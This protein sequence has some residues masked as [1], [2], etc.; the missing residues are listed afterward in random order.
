MDFNQSFKYFVDMTNAKFV[1]M[2]EEMSL[3]RS[4]FSRWY[5]SKVLPNKDLWS[6]I[7]KKMVKYFSERMTP[8]NIEEFLTLRNSIRSEYDSSGLEIV[9]DSVLNSG[10]KTSINRLELEEEKYITDNMAFA[11][12]TVGEFMDVLISNINMTIG[13]ESKSRVDIYYSDDLIDALDH[14]F[15]DGLNIPFTSDQFYQFNYLANSNDDLKDREIIFDKITKFFRLSEKLPFMDFKIYED[16]DLEPINKFVVADKLGGYSNKILDDDYYMGFA[17]KNKETIKLIEEQLRE[18]FSNLNLVIKS[19]IDFQ[20][21]YKRMEKSK[22]KNKIKMFLP[23]LS[24]FMFSYDLREILFDKGVIDKENYRV[25][26]TVKSFFEHP[27]IMS[28]DIS[29]PESSIIK[30]VNNGIITTLKGQIQLDRDEIKLIKKEY[31]DFYEERLARSKINIISTDIQNIE[32]LPKALIYSDKT[33]SC[34]IRP[35]Y[36][37]KTMRGEFYNSIE[38]PYLSNM[39]YEYLL[40]LEKLNEGE[41][42][43]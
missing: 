20:E 9:I 36:Q 39:F 12:E 30:F 10:Y 3:D 38:T 32:R 11:I 40:A 15:I 5:N 17:L 13:D 43:L 25:W 18:K 19:S 27:C 7:R 35:R 6:F 21:S 41:Y 14:E 29:I 24:I 2:A 28:A 33:F 26:E 31:N 4:N 8:E 34:F 23:E 37:D 1:E 42:I 16:D 22:S